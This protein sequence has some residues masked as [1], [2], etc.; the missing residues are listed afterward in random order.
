MSK[1]QKYLQQPENRIRICRA[2]QA[3]FAAKGDD[4]FVGA[5]LREEYRWLA[6][7]EDFDKTE[8]F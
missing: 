8:H 2:N 1:I 4:Q 3:L 6:L 7:A 5:C